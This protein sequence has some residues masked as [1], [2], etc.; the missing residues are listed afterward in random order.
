LLIPPAPESL[1]A[2]ALRTASDA[3]YDPVKHSFWKDVSGKPITPETTLFSLRQKYRIDEE[4][5][6]RFKSV[7][8]QFVG[9][10]NFWNFTVG[11]EFKEA[12]A[13]RHIKSIEVCNIV[14]SDS[15]PNQLYCRFPS[16]VSTETENG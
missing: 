1:A 5:L 16:R 4:T 7:L 2:K 13:Q 11:R 8:E 6:E 9:T 14:L 10:H 15:N 3:P 12:A